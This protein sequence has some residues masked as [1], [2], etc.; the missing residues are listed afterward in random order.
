MTCLLASCPIPKICQLASHPQVKSMSETTSQPQHPISAQEN[1]T[2]LDLFHLSGAQVQQGVFLFII[3]RLPWLPWL[4]TLFID[5][6]LSI[7]QKDQLILGATASMFPQIIHSQH[8][9]AFV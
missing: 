7:S 9:N 5:I 2:R 4:G 1:N 8:Q 3:S 6:G